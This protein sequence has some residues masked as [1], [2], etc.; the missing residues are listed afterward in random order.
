MWTT[1]SLN[2]NDVIDDNSLENCHAG[3]ENGYNNDKEY[4]DIE[5]ISWEK[6]T[7]KATESSIVPKA[8]QIPCPTRWGGLKR[9]QY[10]V[11]S[12]LIVKDVKNETKF[13]TTTS[14]GTNTLATQNKKE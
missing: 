3:N 1:T 6:A 2:N 8:Q 13:M 7:I 10:Y 9:R 11:S 14:R 5:D 4:I 12:G